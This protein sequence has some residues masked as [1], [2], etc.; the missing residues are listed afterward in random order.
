MKPEISPY[1]RTSNISAGYEKIKASGILKGVLTRNNLIVIPLVFLLGRAGLAGGLTPFGIA[2][3]AA[4]Y[5]TEVNRV[6]AGL[7][8]LTGMLSAGAGGQLY[9]AVAGMLLFNVFLLPVKNPKQVSAVRLSGLS[10]AGVMIP[11]LVMTYLQGFLLFDILKSLLFSFIVFLSFF[12]FRRATTA[13][14]G[15]QNKRALTGEETI[16]F[17]IVASLALSGLGGVELFGFSIKSILCV[18]IILLFSHRSGAGAGAAIGVTVGLIVSMSTK[19]SPVVIGSF[20]FCGLVAGVLRNLGKMG[21]SLGFVLGNALITLYLNGSTEVLV[22]LRETTVAVVLFLIMPA[23]FSEMI[24]GAFARSGELSLDKLGY[25]LRIKEITVE[26]LNKFSRAF[27]ELSKTFR[28]IS[29]TTVVTD[30]QDITSLFDRVADRV[31]KDCSLCLHCWDRNFY[32]T[33]QVMFKIIEKLDSRGRIEVRDIP[34][35]FMERCER[36]EDFVDAVNNMYELFKVDIVWKSRI[37]ESRNLVSQQLDGLSRV[38]SNL[39]GEI[40]MDVHFKSDLEDKIILELSRAGIRISDAIVYE[41]KWGK[42]EVSVFHKGCGGKRNCLTTIEKTVSGAVSRKMI[43][44][45]GDCYQR[46][47]N[48]TCTLKLVEEETFRVTT[49]VARLPKNEDAVSGDSYT[50]MSTGDGKYILALSDGMGSGQK[51][52]TQSRAAIS[53]LEQFMET[54]FDKDT[55]VKLI[56]S[57]M[58]LKSDDESFAT[59]D[60]TIIDLYDGEAEFVKIG[61]VPTFIKKSERLDTIKS[62]TL[63]AGILS[64][65]ETELLHRRVESGDLIIMVTDG[66]YDTLR[67]D[68]GGGRELQDLLKGISGTNP[69]QIAE[70]I[71]NEAF[72]ACDGKPQDDMTVLVA[73]IWKK[74]K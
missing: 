14:T 60:I 11:Q 50:F 43:K 22:Y 24:T 15:F 32:N 57:I 38:I 45:S 73:K 1:R 68:E 25:S 41:N 33:Y 46:S 6:M 13:V 40:D 74:S 49:G 59:L 51:A 12:I 29:Q 17:A 7:A 18:L 56:N 61:A 36:I 48:A 39:A 44:E 69:Q 9:I 47:K 3:Y 8:V 52:A 4:T 37:G 63:P 5:G 27:K 66:I 35:Y 70:E 42:F 31:C 58:V 23:K 72:T 54:G 20:A 16:S 55:T 26:K 28:E 34:E 2:A 64:E 62:A 19:V 30:R 21:S 10:F 65:L 67:K 53:L 71:L